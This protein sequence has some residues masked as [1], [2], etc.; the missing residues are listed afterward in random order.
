MPL[1]YNGRYFALVEVPQGGSLY[2]GYLL[3]SGL[4]DTI[5]SE[6]E[7]WQDESKDYYLVQVVEV[8]RF[9]S[10]PL[11]SKPPL[12]PKWVYEKGQRD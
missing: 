10:P 7:S 12:P 5:R 2:R 4:E 8:K 11:P 9:E 3:T 6:F 1:P